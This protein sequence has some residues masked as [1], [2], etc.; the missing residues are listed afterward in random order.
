[1]WPNIV[2]LVIPRRLQCLGHVARMM[3][4][5]KAYRIFMENI[6]LQDPDGDGIIT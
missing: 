4:T 3:E 6:H 1:M 2:G 5:R